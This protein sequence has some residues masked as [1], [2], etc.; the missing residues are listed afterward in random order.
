MDSWSREESGFVVLAGAVAGMMI[1]R[2]TVML[3]LE[4]VIH[5]DSDVLRWVSVILVARVPLKALI[6]DLGGG[7]RV[8]QPQRSLCIDIMRKKRRKR[9]DAASTFFETFEHPPRNEKLLKER[10]RKETA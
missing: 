9:R 8:S 1:S 7:N 6:D 5:S 3:P 2:G 10:D 4:S